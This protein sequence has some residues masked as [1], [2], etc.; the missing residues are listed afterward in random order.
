MDRCL[1][2]HLAKFLGSQEALSGSLKTLLDGIMILVK[3]LE[4]VFDLAKKLRSIWENLH[5]SIFQKYFLA[6]VGKLFGL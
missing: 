2:L 5:F 4:V 3:N 6:Y 1:R